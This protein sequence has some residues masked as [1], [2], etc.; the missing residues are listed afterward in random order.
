M[1]EAESTVQ[2]P[3][4]ANSRIWVFESSLGGEHADRAAEI[5]VKYHGAE[6]GKG[7]G[8]A[9]T[10]YALQTRDD[11]HVLLPP[12][13]IQ[14]N[15]QE[16]RDYVTAHPDLKFQ[17]IH[18]ALSK[19]EQEHAHFADLLRNVPANCEIPGKMLE[20]LERLDT[21]RVILL[22]ANITVIDTD[23]R[24]QA[25][26]QYFAA[27]EGLWSAEHVEIVSIGAAQSLITNDKYAK[28]RGYSHRIISIDSDLYGNDTAAAR[29]MLSITYATKL[30]CL[31]DPSS[32]STTGHIGALQLAARGGLEIESLLIQ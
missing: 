16:F 12:K 18:C 3:A 7:S 20:I 13:D 31:D 32:T 4:I 2:Q 27:N 24:K 14:D 5:A 15:V 29:E 30:I 17:L 19:S 25:L 26:D 9:G 28:D 1:S 21:V 11:E 10:S 8:A 23:A 6:P 22:D